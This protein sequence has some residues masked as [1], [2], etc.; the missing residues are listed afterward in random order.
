V[1]FASNWHF[2]IKYGF[3]EQYIIGF[4]SPLVELRSRTL[5]RYAGGPSSNPG[6]NLFLFGLFYLGMESRVLMSFKRRMRTAYWRVAL[7]K[8]T[9]SVPDPDP[10]IFGPPVS[11]S[12]S[13]GM[14]RIWSRIL[15]IKQK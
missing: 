2:P 10:H 13:R 3:V 6:N 9:S 5:A 12:I 4:D 15:L 8:P 7:P 11:G 14:A 1:D